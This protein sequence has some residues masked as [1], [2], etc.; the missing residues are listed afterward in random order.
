MRDVSYQ[1]RNEQGTKI[2]DTFMSINQTTK[3]LSLSFYD[4]VYD[5]VSGHFNL[6]SLCTDI[7]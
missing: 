4:Y 3:K 1:T 7:K 2:K 6:P 5:R